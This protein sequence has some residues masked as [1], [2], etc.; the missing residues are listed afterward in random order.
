MILGVAVGVGIGSGLFG[1][2][3]E[4]EHSCAGKE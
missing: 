4:M 2:D 1:I 3:S